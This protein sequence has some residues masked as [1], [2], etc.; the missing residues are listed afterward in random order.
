MKIEKFFATHPVFTIAEFFCYLQ[1]SSS[2]NHNTA[3]SLL[4]YHKKS[5]HILQVRRGLFATVPITQDVANF[6]VNPFLIAGRIADDSVVSHHAA[7]E[8]HGIAYSVFNHFYYMTHQQIRAFEFQ[9]G[10]FKA[11]HFPKNLLKLGEENFSIAT[12]NREGLDIKITTIERTLVD[13]LHRPDYSGGWEEIWLSFSAISVLRLEHVI[14]Y[15]L[16][17]DNATTIA[18]VGFFLE[19]HQEQFKVDEDCLKKLETK[20]PAN[21]HYL[22]RSKRSFGKLMKRWNL[23]VPEKILN[24]YWEEPNEIF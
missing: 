14:E 23:I 22:E 1:Q 3:K 2:Y 18:K 12:V 8:L 7:M 9:G 6:Q 24:Q 16:L 13:S 19:Q 20:I 4:N 21:K 11:L 17:L 10:M 15:A 5:G